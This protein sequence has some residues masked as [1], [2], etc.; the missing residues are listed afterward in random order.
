MAPLS[1]NRATWRNQMRC[2]L[3]RECEYRSA[4]ALLMDNH[5]PEL[6]FEPEVRTLQGLNQLKQ[7]RVRDF[8]NEHPDVISVCDTLYLVGGAMPLLEAA[9]AS[10]VNSSS[11]CNLLWQQAAG[12]L[13]DAFFLFIEGRLDSGFALLRMSVELARDTA[14][15][16]AFPS[17]EA[18]WHNREAERNE[19]R[20]VFRF[21]TSAPLGSSAQAIYKICTRYGVHGHTTNLFHFE[22]DGTAN[23]GK[24]LASF[25][26]S[27]KGI[28]EGVGFWMRSFAPVHGLCGASNCGSGPDIYTDP[29][30]YEKFRETVR[31][32]MPILNLLETWLTEAKGEART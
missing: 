11:W 8:F 12:Y 30:L 15:L 9:G 26:V 20:K 25:K 28:I 22:K 4:S 27:K 10:K 31:S 13:N 21:D 32:L 1:G 7:S 14:I 24:N 23:P 2:S 3:R 16:R 5:T 19:Y 18:L 17:N 6:P 29:E